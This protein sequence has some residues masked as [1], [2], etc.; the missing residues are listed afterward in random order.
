[1]KKSVTKII[2]V[3]LDQLDRPEVSARMEIDPEKIDELAQSISEQG[4]LQ[5]ILI[6]PQGKRFEIVAGDRRFLAVTSLGWK[7]IPAIVK[8][9]DDETTIINRATEN[10]FRV[11]VSPIEQ[12]RTFKDLI[13]RCG[14][15][16]AKIAERMKLSEGV[17]RR[18][19]D[20]L[21]MPPCLQDAIHKKQIGYA[22][23]EELWSLGDVGKIEY[24][25]GFCIDHG[26]TKDVV[27][28]WVKEEKAKERQAE[29]AGAE[30]SPASSPMERRPVFVTCDCCHGP[31]ELGQESIL[32][33]C[34]V[35][36]RT[37][38]ENI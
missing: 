6:R 15:N 33:I 34:P 5:P 8:D 17:V 35:C 21:R 30:G 24:Y 16:P 1:M 31:V 9:Q 37:I 23:G 27:R 26:A 29:R 19:L 10:I 25:L 36:H 32:R 28:S 20:L 3:A 11:D 2:D 4:L 12:A 7:T 13:D 22:V 14:M 38:K 18:R